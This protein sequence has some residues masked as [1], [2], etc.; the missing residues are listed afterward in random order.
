M[1]HDD[2][3]VVL[4]D[5]DEYI[6]FHPAEGFELNIE[7]GLPIEGVKAIEE[8]IKARKEIYDDV[9]KEVYGVAAKMIFVPIIGIDDEVIR[10]ISCAIDFE[11]NEKIIISISSLTEIISQVTESVEELAKSSE[12]LA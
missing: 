2:M 3:A 4:T 8:S 12:G 7:E 10:T 1:T 5:L 11:D 9:D 6:E